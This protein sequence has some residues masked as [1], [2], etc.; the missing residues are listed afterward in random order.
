MSDSHS[1]DDIELPS[2]ARLL[3]STLL[4]V[5]SAALILVFIVLPSEY[6]IGPGELGR[7]FGF[8]RAPAQ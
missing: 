6:G 5:V 1:T 3:R 4:A 2:G 8:G 7:L